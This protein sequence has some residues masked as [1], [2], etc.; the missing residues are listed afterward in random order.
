MDIKFNT[1]ATKLTESMVR[2]WLSLNAPLTIVFSVDAADKAGFEAIRIGADF[3]KVVANIEMFN[4]IRRDEFPDSPVRTRV[5]MTLFKDDQ[6]PE[7]ARKLWGSLVDEFTAKNA[8]G[9][10]SGGIYQN[11]ADGNPKNISPAVKCRVLFDRLYVWC[12]GK[13]NPC[14]DD[15]MSKLAIGNAC[16]SSL[17][18]LWQGPEMMRLRIAHLTGKKNACYPCNGCS[19]Y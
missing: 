18:D 9:E 2:E 4:R 1:N 8:R 11:G 14:E 19:G 6:D 15:Y 5:S 12:D 10:Q 7:A 16:Q 3:D 17:K 13:V